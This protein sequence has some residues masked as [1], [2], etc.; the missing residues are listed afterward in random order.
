MNRLKD[1]LDISSED[2]QFKH[3]GGMKSMTLRGEY[4]NDFLLTN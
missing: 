4:I 3:G 2:K 1:E